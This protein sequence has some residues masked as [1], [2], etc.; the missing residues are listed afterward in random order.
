MHT[1]WRPILSKFIMTKYRGDTL[2]EYRSRPF[3][4]LSLPPD[5]HRR[6]AV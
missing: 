5:H 3:R 2:A 4:R 6:I 1:A